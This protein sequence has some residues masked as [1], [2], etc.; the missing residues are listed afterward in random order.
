MRR[1]DDLW[2]LADEADRRAERAYH[3][4][5]DAYAGFMEAG[6][7]RRVSRSRFRTLAER[8]KETGAPFGS[9]TIVH[10]DGDVALVRHDHVDRWVLPGGEPAEG[11]TYRETA[12]R[13]L[14]EEAGITADYEGLAMAN[15]VD[16][17][18][19]GYATWGVLPV[20]AA[21]P[22]TTDLVVSDPDGEI[23]DADWFAFDDLPPDTRDR[24]LLRR[25]FEGE[26]P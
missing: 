22:E 2:F 14:A 8:V 19:D 21:R 4:L 24:D 5:H 13:E 23:S 9:H 25:W 6:L 1:F 18:C 10:R 15:R 11:E 16:I 12:Q 7:T 26:A 17:R 20:F 3:R